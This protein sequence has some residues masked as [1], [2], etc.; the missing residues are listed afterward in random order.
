MRAAE[1]AAEEA[2]RSWAELLGEPGIRSLER[3]LRQ[4]APYEPLQPA[5]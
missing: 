4:I 1:E 5:W 3:Q 2:V